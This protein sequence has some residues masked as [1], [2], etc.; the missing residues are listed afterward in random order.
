MK[1]ACFFPLV[2]ASQPEAH[3]TPAAD[4]KTVDANAAQIFSKPAYLNSQ[5]VLWCQSLVRVWRGT[6]ASFFAT[7]S[8]RPYKFLRGQ[9]EKISHLLLARGL[10]VLVQL[11]QLEQAEERLYGRP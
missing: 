7:M 11:P 4:Q 8:A 1:R 9:E 6:A 10:V 5:R 2:T 3:D